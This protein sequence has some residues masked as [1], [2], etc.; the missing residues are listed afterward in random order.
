MKKKNSFLRKRYFVI[1][2]FLILLAG[3]TL[4]YSALQ[5]TLSIN[6]TTNI[7]AVN[8]DIHF[9]NLAVTSGSVAIGTGNSA[10]AIDA[11][12]PTKITYNI[13]LKNPGDFYEFTVDVK[14]A[15]TIDAKLNN[16]VK[17]SL[18]P[19]QDAYTNYTVKYTDETIPAIG[20]QLAHGASKKL[21]VRIEFDTNIEPT[22]LPTE[23]ATFDLEYK[24]TYV[25]D[26]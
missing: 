8:W 15:G 23:G 10:A 3:I 20:N 14:N 2:L 9:E 4:G 12:D 16:I 25:Q 21:L 1:A 6:G 13:T 17:T 19:A 18:T 11:N 24:L 7:D 26:R 22:D 5:T